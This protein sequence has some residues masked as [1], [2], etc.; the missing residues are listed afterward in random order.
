MFQKKIIIVANLVEIKKKIFFKKNLKEKGLKLIYFSRITKKKNLIQTLKILKKFQKNFV[1]DIYGTI[2]DPIY[3]NK[4]KVI[5]DQI[6]SLKLKVFYK[7]VFKRNNLNSILNKYHFSILLSDHE[8]FGHSIIDSLINFTPVIT[9]QNVYWKE[10]ENYNIGWNI[11]KITNHDFVLKILNKCYDNKNNFNLDRYK[12]N[13][14]KYLKV[15]YKED[16]L[17][18]KYFNIFNE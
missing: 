1:L 14:T 16:Q 13:L 17:L 8:N 3:W 7:G 10:L 2:D 9:T 11:K 6:N 4:C 12:Q 5:I 18:S 15:Y